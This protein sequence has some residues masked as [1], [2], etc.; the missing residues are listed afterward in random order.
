MKD[1]S[2]IKYSTT[3]LTTMT[4]TLLVTLATQSALSHYRLRPSA[5]VPDFVST[6]VQVQASDSS[7]VQNNS[8]PFRDGLWLGGVAARHGDPFHVSVSRWNSK[9]DRAAF[10]IGYRQGYAHEQAKHLNPTL[11]QLSLSSDIAGSQ[12]Q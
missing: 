5:D 6:A 10:V 11:L 7:T 9:E 12:K 3:I 8:A 2:R 1:E 4:L